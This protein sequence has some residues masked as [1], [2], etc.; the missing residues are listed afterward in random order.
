M[1]KILHETDIMVH[2]VSNVDLELD[3]VIGIALFFFISQKSDYF[4]CY[5]Y[6]LMMLN[7]CPDRDSIPGPLNYRSEALSTEL[8]RHQ[9][10]FPQ[11][12]SLVANH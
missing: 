4:N 11:S 2:R 7:D 3:E 6:Y 9:S 12:L 8:H 5:Y 1:E 10:T